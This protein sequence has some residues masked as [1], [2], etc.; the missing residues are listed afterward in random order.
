MDSLMNEV[1]YFLLIS[2]HSKIIKIKNWYI[3]REL[4]GEIIRVGKECT[5]DIFAGRIPNLPFFMLNGDFFEE[6]KKPIYFKTENCKHMQGDTL[7]FA[8]MYPS[9]N[10]WILGAMSRKEVIQAAMAVTYTV[11]VKTLPILGN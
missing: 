3:T 8:E 9:K 11:S 2:E 10:G 7:V 4:G 1:G 5:P 6:D